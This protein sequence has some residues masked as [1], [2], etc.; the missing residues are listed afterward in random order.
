MLT[1]AKL[2]KL[3]PPDS[4]SKDPSKNKAMH[5]NIE[6]VSGYF[7]SALEELRCKLRT[8]GKVPY[9]NAEFL[10]QEQSNLK[11]TVRKGFETYRGHAH[12]EFLGPTC[13]E[14]RGLANFFTKHNSTQA[15]LRQ[16]TKE[17]M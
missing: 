17:E 8:T 15:S 9:F 1:S 7:D 10:P 2:Y 6:R 3:G 12:F 11:G 13:T 5:M 4:K 16:L 14:L